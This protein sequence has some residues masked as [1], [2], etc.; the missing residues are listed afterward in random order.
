M[1]LSVS[2][3]S[4]RNFPTK[5]RRVQVRHW[6]DVAR[7]VTTE[8]WSPIVWHDGQ[9]RSD[10][11]SAAYFAAL[12]IDDG[13]SLVEAITFLRNQGLS[14]LIV[15][16]KSHGKA[17]G[18]EAPRDRFRLLMPWSQEIIKPSVYRFNLRRLAENWNADMAATDLARVFQPGREIV[19]TASGGKATVTIPREPD[20]R[21]VDLK[22]RYSVKRGIKH[23]AEE[24]CQNGRLDHS[25]GRKRTIYSVAC[26]LA[27]S[28]VSASE[29][30]SLI[31]RAPINWQ[32]LTSNLV[33]SCV[34]SAQRRFSGG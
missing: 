6:G 15:T 23:F 13:L 12:D 21:M 18:E 11:F 24:F 19:S 4:R 30:I 31:Q 34:E 3:E 14:H 7:I 17:K 26:E 25:G 29:S 8:R 27:K 16:T 2:T 9:R 10:H 32:G 33:T 5:F 28:G 1:Y 20:K 22:S